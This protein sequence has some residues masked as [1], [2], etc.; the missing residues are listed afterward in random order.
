MCASSNALCY[1]FFGPS[2]AANLP[3][4]WLVKWVTEGIRWSED[5]KY[6]QINRTLRS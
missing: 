5:I 6:Q 3:K 2:V 1:C 4:T